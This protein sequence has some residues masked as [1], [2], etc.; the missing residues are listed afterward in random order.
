MKIIFIFKYSFWLTENI[1]IEVQ[2]KVVLSDFNDYSKTG[3]Y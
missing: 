1:Y 3:L 2:I